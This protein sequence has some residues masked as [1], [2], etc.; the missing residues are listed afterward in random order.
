[1]SGVVQDAAGNTEITIDGISGG[2]STRT[3]PHLLPDN[4]LAVA[5]NVVYY[6]DGLCG[7]RPGNGKYGG[8]GDIGTGVRTLALSRFYFGNPIAGQL[9]AQ[10]NGHLWTGNDGTGAFTDQGGGFSTTQPWWTAPIFDPE[11]GAG[12]TT[13]FITDG[14]R[15]P[16]MW[17]G[18]AFVGVSTAA[19]KLP[20]GRT[21]APITPK[22]CVNYGWH[23]VYA[24]EPTE[25]SGVYFSDPM[26][27]E[28]FTGT[29]FIDSGGTSY[30]PDFPS[31]RDGALGDV[32]GLAVVGPYLI[33]FF[34]G[35]IVSA[36]NTGSIGAFNYV[37]S[38][39]S[40]KVGTSSSKS[41]I[42]YDTFASFFGGDR[43]YATDG[44]SVWPLPDEIPT[45]Y[46]NTAA[47]SR[48]PEIKD[49]TTVIGVSRQQQ[50]WASYD[51]DNSGHQK[52]QV[53]F[54]FAANGGWTPAPLPGVPNGGAWARWLGM[55]VGAAVECRGSGD[56]GQLFWADSV[57]SQVYQH[58]V[59]TYDDVGTAISMEVRAKSFFLDRPITSKTVLKIYPMVIFDATGAS[60]QSQFQPYVVLDVNQQAL[61]QVIAQAIQA[62][63]AKWGTMTWGTDKWSAIGTGYFQ[64]NPVGFEGY[65]A[66]A[67]SVAPGVVEN[68]KNPFNII[69]FVIVAVIDEPTK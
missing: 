18:A 21:G 26:R 17:D 58:D 69:G 4:K 38:R 51:F 45:V 2:W 52:R 8:T 68:S 3:F 24:G 48:P 50:Y 42:N 29:S 49:K 36:Y 1:M 33:I 62:P 10:N 59:G 63:G 12:K 25:P 28:S 35:G 66:T 64:F 56:T 67:N 30:I 46:A 55:N 5:D 6:R 61:A 14:G 7:K 32:T 31:G 9:L 40:P 57:S 23:I 37:F 16:Q 11:N 53:V 47:S 19:G 44:V 43:F 27:P 34:R 65:G 22:F 60:Y 20:N 41:I 54:D 15:I 39:I 13:L